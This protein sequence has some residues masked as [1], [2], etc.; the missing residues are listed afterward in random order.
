MNA[1]TVNGPRSR[2]TSSSTSAIFNSSAIDNLKS[3]VSPSLF[4]HRHE[5][6]SL[7]LAPDEDLRE[8]SGGHLLQ[9]TAGF[10]RCR[11]ALAVD[12][13]NHVPLSERT[14]RGTVRVDLGDERPG[15]AGRN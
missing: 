4:S 5:D 13:E 8:T 1:A 7:A 14:G 9:L 10:G 6:L 3:A 12:R 11:H 15:L 2:M